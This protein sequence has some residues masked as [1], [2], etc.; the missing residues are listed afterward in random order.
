M[1]RSVF[2]PG[3]RRLRRSTMTSG[4]DRLAARREDVTVIQQATQLVADLGV[5]LDLQLEKEHRPT[6][7]MR[8]LRETTNRITRAAN[9]A[10]SAYARTRRL[11]RVEMER[12]DAD[13]KAVERITHRLDAARGDLLQALE[14][15][16]QRYPT[17]EVPAAAA[18]PARE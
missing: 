10:V 17:P 9:D 4:R 11:L 7:R 6:E 3:A 8:M 16:S 5:Q 12:P 1:R 15:A 18:Q 14:R 2:G 13:V